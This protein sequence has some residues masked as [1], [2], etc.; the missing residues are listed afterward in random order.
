MKTKLRSFL[1]Q[2]NGGIAIVSGFVMLLLVTAIGAAVDYSQAV[3][4]RQGLSN[5]LDSA[6]LATARDLSFHR[7]TEDEAANHLQ[8]YFD[9]AYP[10]SY[11]HDITEQKPLAISVDVVNGVVMATANVAMPTA[12]M[13]LAGFPSLDIGVASTARYVQNKLDIALVVDVTGSMNDRARSFSTKTKME[14]LREAVRDDFLGSLFAD[15]NRAASTDHIRVSLVPYISSVNISETTPK[16]YQAL[17]SK[18]MAES[19]LEVITDA[20]PGTG[21]LIG[22]GRSCLGNASLIPLTNNPK[23]IID[24]LEEIN[25]KGATAGHIGLL[26]GWNTIST[27]WISEW[28]PASQPSPTSDREVKKVLVLMSDGLFNRKYDRVGTRVENGVEV[29]EL[30][31]LGIKSQTAAIR[32]EAVRDS[33]TRARSACDQMHRDGLVVYTIAFA[34]NAGSDAEAVLRDCA[35]SVSSHF[36]EAGGGELGAAFQA[37]AVDVKRIWL[38]S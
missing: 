24:R 3:N 26:W 14:E 32:A 37:I 18:C 33:G 31:Y 29:A 13:G 22:N 16:S 34:L 19:G 38:S 5:A 10:F 23:K 8:A 17:N 25:P 4:A 12:F 35:T 15:L 21:P 30:D 9:K 36:F 27:K 11:S 6:T 2:T 7:I 28:P 20:A 1:R